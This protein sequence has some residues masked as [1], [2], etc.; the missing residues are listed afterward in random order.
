MNSKR[1]DEVQPWRPNVE[2][3][4]ELNPFTNPLDREL[5]NPPPLE[6]SHSEDGELDHNNRGVP[7]EAASA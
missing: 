5:E 3:Q 6:E 1:K 4:S 2:R 7:D